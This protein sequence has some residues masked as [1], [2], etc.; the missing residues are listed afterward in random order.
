MYK[1]EIIKDTKGARVVC[2]DYW[3]VDPKAAITSFLKAREAAL[4]EGTNILNVHL[5]CNR[6]PLFIMRKEPTFAD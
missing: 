6:V 5:S 3:G 1:V 2:P 4:Q